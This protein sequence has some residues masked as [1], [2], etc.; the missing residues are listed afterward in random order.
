VPAFPKAA[1]NVAGN[2]DACDS[3][4]PSPAGAISF[5]ADLLVRVITI[6]SPR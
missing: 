5:V 1:S 3:S 6:S 2:S 4:D